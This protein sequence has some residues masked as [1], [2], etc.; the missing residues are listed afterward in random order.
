M[1]LSA[2]LSKESEAGDLVLAS[3]VRI[4]ADHLRGLKGPAQ[5]LV[6]VEGL[7]LDI[8]ENK[9]RRILPGASRPNARLA[10]PAI[11]G[12]DALSGLPCIIVI[13]AGALRYARALEAAAP[14]PVA[15]LDVE[16]APAADP[17]PF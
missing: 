4:G 5:T 9:T 17:I 14:A 13:Q 15:A 3:A 7:D 1:S 2:F 12:K 6:A 8:Q 10:W 16:P 11:K